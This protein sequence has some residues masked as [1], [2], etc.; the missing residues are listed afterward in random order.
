MPFPISSF[1]RI[2]PGLALLAAS[3]LVPALRRPDGWLRP[4]AWISAVAGIGLGILGAA[5]AGPWRRSGALFA[6][7]LTGQACALGL[8]DSPS[9]NVL[10]HYFPWREICTWPRV[11][12]L[13]GPVAQ[14]VV[15]AAAWPAARSAVA[16][17]C[18][19]LPRP[20]A[21]ALLGFVAFS[22]ANGSRDLSRYLGELALALWILAVNLCN[23]ALVAA[24]VPGD[25]LAAAAAWIGARF[26]SGPAPAS[27]WDRWLPRVAAAWVTLVS[28][29]LAGWVF[30]GIPHIPDDIA[31]WFQAKYFAAGHLYLPAPPDRESFEVGQV[32]NDGA[33]WYGYGS[34]G[35]PAVLA[36]GVWVGAPWLVN[37]LL[38]GAS[39]LLAHAWLRRLGDRRVAN[40]V[41]LLLAASP[42][43]LFMGASFLTHTLSV[44]AT[45]ACLLAVERARSARSAGL[46]AL[47]GACLGAAFLARPLEGVLVA[48]P[49]GLWC[50]GLGAARLPL[51]ALAAAGAAGLALGGLV[52]PYNRALTGDP[53]TF[54]IET[55]TD[56]VWY[57]G[58][59]R[60]G[61]G[62]DIGNVGWS[63]LDPLPGHGLLDVVLNAN[64]NFYMA[65]F[66]L[67]GW[68]FGSLGFAALALS[69][70][71][72]RGPDGLLLGLIAS[73]VAGHSLYWFSGGPDIGARYWYATLVPFVALGVRGMAEARRRWSAAGGGRLGALRLD[74]F[75]VAASLSALVNVIPVRSLGKYHDY[76]GVRADIAR[77]SDERGFGRSLV[78]VREAHKSDYP[79]AFLF[80][81]ATLAGDGTIYARDAGARQR[82]AVEAAFPDRP[83]WVVGSHEPG[84]PFTVLEGPLPAAGRRPD[85][86]RLP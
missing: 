25:R 83:V 72:W 39:V 35:W 30:E 21:L 19:L 11:L 85:S 26:G 27:R 70:R 32:V 41:C 36:L 54:P 29:A 63:H 58:A 42:W 77:L 49:I 48:L 23:L 52:F 10:E 84:A 33:K 53:T 73:I 38:S 44:A 14:L 9:Y 20:A 46:A 76:R 15:V 37:P 16:R 13:A 28:A 61:F 24:A 34:P 75:V 31:Y 78:F 18:R 62:A 65:S 69:W 8:R 4:E 55:W 79:S 68:A 17:A 86:R 1:A 64:Q 60:I 6:L 67:F 80:N 66:E 81:P 74:A 12:L 59:N 2:A 50:L 45:L 5:W 43:L 7:A 40:A 57:P 56:A 51:R 3:L 22:A 82:A 71:C 47:A